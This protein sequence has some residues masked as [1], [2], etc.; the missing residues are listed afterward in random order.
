MI[1]LL[2]PF[3]VGKKMEQIIIKIET[4][5]QNSLSLIMNF[6]RKNYNKCTKQKTEIQ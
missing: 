5:E 3:P 1:H 4:S 6:V 2:A